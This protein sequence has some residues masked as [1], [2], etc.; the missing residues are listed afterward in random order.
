MLAL[1][2]GSLCIIACINKGTQL[3]ELA[4]PGE[5]W[6]APDSLIL[7]TDSTKKEIRYGR[8][9]IT[10]TGKYLGPHGS[11]M[12]I[13]NGM[14]CQNCHLNAGTKPFGNNFSAVASTYPKFR[15]RSGTIESIE[16]RVNDCFERSLNGQPLAEDSREMKAIVSYLKWLGTNVTQ[17]ESPPGAGLPELPFLTIAASPEMGQP[18]FEKKCSICHGKNG[19][20]LKAED[21]AWIYPPLWGAESYNQ[22]AG[23][24][25]LSRFAGFIKANMPSGTTYQ[26]PQ[27]TDAEAWHIAAYVNSMPRPKKDL[28][29][30]WPEI[31]K[32]PIDHPFGPYADGFSEWQHKYGP[33]KPMV[34]SRSAD[35]EKTK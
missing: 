4:L 20:G 12:A 19:E 32:K 6:Q 18:L 23:L 34:Q 25:R 29:Q 24:F 28:T 9:L 1:V 21:H 33:F 3:K 5:V 31:S 30:D 16:K 7:F 2:A 10:H 11:V 22:G 27:L 26:Q 14:N 35:A 13:S 8:E 17:G 15:A